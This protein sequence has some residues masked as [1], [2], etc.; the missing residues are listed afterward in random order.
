MCES[1]SEFANAHVWFGGPGGGA[2]ELSAGE[3]DG[4]GAEPMLRVRK[5]TSP[6]SLEKGDTERSCHSG[7]PKGKS[8]R[9]VPDEV[10]G[11]RPEYGSNRFD[12]RR[13]ELPRGGDS[14]VDGSRCDCERERRGSRGEA[15]GDSAWLRA[16]AAEY[17]RARDRLCVTRWAAKSSALKCS[18]VRKGK[19][20]QIHGSGCSVR[21]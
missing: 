19:D 12:P 10:G 3:A 9:A 16:E 6:L 4:S 7:L 15:S 20:R 8:N 18:S 14:G 1:P 5:V 21:D 17:D 13:D 2:D 11:S